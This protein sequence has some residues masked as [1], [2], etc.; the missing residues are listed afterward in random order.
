MEYTT[1]NIRNIFIKYFTNKDHQFVPSSSVIP[2]NDPSLLFVNAG[3]NQFKDIILGEKEITYKRAVN[4]QK[5]I[6]AGGKHNDLDDIGKDVYHHTFFEMLGSWSFGDYWKEEI[7]GYAYDLLI[8]VYGLDK[9]KIYVTY[10]SGTELLEEDIETKILWSK[11]ISTDR[12]L[13]FGMKENFWEMGNTGPCGPCTEIHY[14]RSGVDRDAKDLVNKDD[15][16]VIEIWNLVF[17]QYNRISDSELL[18]LKTRHVDTGMGLERLVSILQNKKSNYDTD[19]FVPIISEI[20]KI[21]QLNGIREY[22]GLVGEID[23]GKID[24]TYRIIADHIRTSTISIGDGLLPGHKANGHVLKKIIRNAI[25]E[26]IIGLNLLDKNTYKF[27]LFLYK[28]VPITCDTLKSHYIYLKDDELI[29]H[30]MAII[31]EEENNYLEV[32]KRNQ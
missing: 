2:N 6:R 7:I 4:S 13:P 20:N 23:V 16:N 31:L 1:D 17:M 21:A 27:E 10:F 9:N 15:P 25:K 28:L 3:M 5:C 18:P 30:I 26:G 22:S 32:L 29:K 11:Y 24:T 8:N 19:A 14:D 12:I